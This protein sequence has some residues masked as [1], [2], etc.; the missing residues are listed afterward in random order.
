ML[1]FTTKISKQSYRLLCKLKDGAR[2]R[3]DKFYKQDFT[4]EAIEK[5]ILREAKKRELV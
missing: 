5:A 1:T 2:K 3:G 4:A